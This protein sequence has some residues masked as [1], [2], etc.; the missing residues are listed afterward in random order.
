MQETTTEP[1][2]KLDPTDIF[3]W[4]NNLI[5]YADEIT[6]TMYFFN[7]NQTPYRAKIPAEITRQLRALFLDHI[8]EYV[9]DGIDKGL[10]VRSFEESVKE[11]LVLQ[12]TEVKNVT[13]L[14][15]LL[16]WLKTEQHN[17]EAFKESEHDLPRMRGVIVS[18]HH[19]DL[20]PFYIIKNVP[21]SQ[22]MKG[23]TAWLIK[24]DT[25][26][27]FDGM[28]ALKIPGDNQLLV[29]GESVFVFSESKLKSLF[30]YDAKATLV[31]ESKVKSIEA[32]FNLSFADNMTMQ[33]LVRESP[34]VV[35]KLQGVDPGK[36]TQ[37]E[38]VRHAEEMGVDLMSDDSGAIIIVDSKDLVKFVNLLNDD[39]MESALTGQRYEI[40]RKKILRSPKEDE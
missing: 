25:F 14:V 30:S 15:T 5:Q 26:K 24:D 36:I 7:K 1:S 12:K 8:L 9:L 32:Q 18:C 3:A 37:A 35:R 39:Y 17:I 2:R 11:E 23:A 19:K 29:I 31:A 6:Y 4:T 22:L 34:G 27:P 16:N 28:S 33:Q 10:I 40:V 20:E 13:K 21:S 38:L